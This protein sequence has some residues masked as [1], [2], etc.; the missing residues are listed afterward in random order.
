[1]LDNAHQ[2]VK[3][4]LFPIELIFLNIE[5]V[6]TGADRAAAPPPPPLGR[7]FISL[8]VVPSEKTPV[9]FP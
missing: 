8:G 7:K 9:F 5:L 1:M 4:S 2:T 6:G 3:K